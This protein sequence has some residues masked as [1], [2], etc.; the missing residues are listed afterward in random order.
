MAKL[1]EYRFL[2]IK[3]VLTKLKKL[4][5]AAGKE[6]APLLFVMLHSRDILDSVKNGPVLIKDPMWL[7]YAMMK[8]AERGADYSMLENAHWF[9]YISFWPEKPKM[10]KFVTKLGAS[11]HS[12]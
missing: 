3:L 10:Y 6:A 2:G 9:Y 12:F 7:R 1:S 11:W 4:E 5:R 8:R